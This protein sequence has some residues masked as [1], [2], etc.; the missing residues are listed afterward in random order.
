MIS[1][2][3][4]LG[5]KLSRVMLQPLAS[6]R[7]VT[8]RPAPLVKSELVITTTVTIA[9]STRSAQRE[10]HFDVRHECKHTGGSHTQ[11]DEGA[12]LYLFRT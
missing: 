3:H 4:S 2:R 11:T 6:S 12:T 5:E 1:P 7:K 9:T 8:I 10:T